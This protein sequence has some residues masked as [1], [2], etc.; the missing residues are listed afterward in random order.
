L[1][2][3]T[4]AA[5]SL[6]ELAARYSPIKRRTIE[7][8]LTLFAHHGVGGTSLQ[9]IADDLGV[10]KAAVYHQ[11]AVKEAIAHAVIEV[12][13]SPIE[14]ALERAESIDPA[15]T[16]REVLLENVVD[17]VVANRRSLSTLQSDPVLFRMLSEYEPSL[18]MWTRLFG[19]LVGD[20]DDDRLR[21][22]ASVVAAAMGSVAYPFVIGLDDQ[23][24]RDELLAI[25]RNLLF[26]RS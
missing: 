13:L 24:V 17:I 16:R 1:P 6:R 15:G 25:T 23:T 22:R 11:F 7:T 8:A 12:E 9:M 10:T 20:D 18:R 2:R 4:P 19:V 3:A 21:V 14:E 5:A 26:E